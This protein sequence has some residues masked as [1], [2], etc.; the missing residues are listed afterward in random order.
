MNY[1][2][3][4]NY[5]ALNYLAFNYAGFACI[6]IIVFLTATQPFYIKE[7][8]GITPKPGTSKDT[9]IGHIVGL[10]GFFDE[11]TAMVVAPLL[12]ALNDNLNIWN[13]SGSK[14]IQSSS[15]IVIAVSLLGFAV[16]CRNLV[17]DMFIFRIIFAI[18]VTGCMSMVT[19]VLN[20]LTM[21]DFLF[22]KF[23]FWR[24]PKAVNYLPLGDDSQ[25]DVLPPSRETDADD[26][27]E[28]VVVVDKKNGKYAG[29][30][31]VCT[32]LGAIFS[33]SVF[34]TLPVKF[35]DSHPDWTM[36][37]GLKYSYL[38]LVAFA[39]VSF[40]VLFSFLYRTRGDLVVDEITT[41]KKS[42][43][44]LLKEGF[45]FSK[46]DKQAQLAYMGA[47]V[48][49]STTVATSMFIPLMVYEWYY[50]I[51]ECKTG[52]GNWAGKISCHEGYVFS[53]ILTGVAQTVA[54]VSAPL[55]GYLVDSPR[56]G[57]TKT[58]AISGVIGLIG[59]MGLS[60]IN[61]SFKQYNPKTVI[62]FVNVSIIGLSQIG[63]IISSMSVLS[64]IP[65][66]HNIMGS[67][68]GFYSFC[69]G[70]GIMIITS[71]GGFL[72]DYWILSPF[73]ILGLFNLGLVA[74]SIRS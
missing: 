38:I 7:V 67:L 14:I 72:S 28:A 64:G 49:R 54:L 53:A 55:W 69:G 21:S 70:I 44:E 45:E 13:Y 35:T 46:T 71:L 27:D 66:A 51:G 1:N 74:I 39:L 4:V 56:V 48:A 23:L 26:D 65:N 61:S 22:S 40:G 6:A 9:K 36:K 42:Y 60:L 34:V 73:F 31:G 3:Y 20:E 63:L 68:S 29:I 33:V 16:M 30:M 37:E 5:S 15:F 17:P 52:N 62:C 47:F 58:L 2:K 43:V 24:R 12:G 11:L 10:L 32:G 50:N 19:V 57:K 41:T 59:N 18:G 8:I 25:E